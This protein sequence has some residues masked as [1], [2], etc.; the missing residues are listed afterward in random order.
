MFYYGGVQTTKGNDPVLT[1]DVLGCILNCLEEKH[2]YKLKFN[3]K[4]LALMRRQHKKGSTKELARQGFIESLNGQAARFKYIC[5]YGSV[6]LVR[7]VIFKQPPNWKDGLYGACKGGHRS[8]V[9]FIISNMAGTHHAWDHGLKGACKGGDREI[10]D[11]MISKGANDWDT[12]LAGACRGG[13][14]ELINLMMSKG[15]RYLY[16]GLLEA[17]RGGHTEIVDFMIA[18]GADS[19]DEGLFAACRGGNRDIV[20][21]IIDKG[22]TGWNRGL[23]GACRG[24]QYDLAKLMISHGADGWNWVYVPPVVAVILSSSI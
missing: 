24:G 6:N 10:V 22:A 17:C 16:R 19:W 23:S 2:W 1:K 8:L 12:G 4:I 3:S 15:V 7:R 9:K 18:K 21:L 13:H 5:E 20:S 11:L 14:I